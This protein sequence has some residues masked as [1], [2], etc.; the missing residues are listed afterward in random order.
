MIK[1]TILFLCTA[2]VLLQGQS[3]Q[4]SLGQV[5][6]NNPLVL[7]RLANYKETTN[8]LGIARSEYLPTLD[9]SSSFGFERTG[10]EN[11]HL[12]AQEDK[13]LNYYENSLTLMWNIFN[14]FGT[15]NKVDYQK[16]RIVASAYNFIEKAD[17]VAFDL[18]RTYIELVKQHELLKISQEN[19][20]INENIFS[21]INDLYKS[22]LTTKSE[23]RKIEASLFLA[24]SNA[25]VQENNNMDAQFNFK[26]VF[27]LSIDSEFV[28]V[29]KFT[30]MLPKT[31]DEAREYVVRNNP[32]IMVSDFNIKAAKYLKKQ[33]AKEFYP[34]LDMIIQQNIDTNTYGIEEDRNRFRAGLTLTYNFYRGGKDTQES[35]KAQQEINRN[36]QTK[37]ELEREAIEGLELSWSADKMTAKQLVELLKYKDY[38]EDTLELYK[39]E[40]NLGKRTLLDLLA[41]QNDF[42]NSKS[43]I[44]K[45]KYDNLFAKYRILDAMGLLIAGVMGNE[46]N[47]MHLVG[48]EDNK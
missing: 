37:S 1:K 10:I 45:A 48:V 12:V 19:V 28:E 6:E 43:Q 7:E 29:P 13:N 31:L 4:N 38:S 32:S 9:L 42:I 44:V 27:G 16:A 14:G 24:R 36:I 5:L 21:K 46:Y 40:Y 30:V 2:T 15:S 22:G 20:E 3:L 41:V 17:D 34:K 35:E 47:Y 39:E 25:V 23:V 26:K 18:T 33:K 11:N 8:D